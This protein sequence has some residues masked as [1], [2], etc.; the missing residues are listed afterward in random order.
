MVLAQ[1][2]LATRIRGQ[3]FDPC[4]FLIKALG[5]GWD[6]AAKMAETP[7]HLSA[8]IPSAQ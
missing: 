7:K 6:G 1:K 5:G 2:R 4:V 3:Q 8:P